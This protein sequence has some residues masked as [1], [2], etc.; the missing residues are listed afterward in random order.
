[1]EG[2]EGNRDS[3]HLRGLATVKGGKNTIS[4]PCAWISHEI[5]LPVV[6]DLKGLPHTEP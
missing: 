2:F 5:P 3:K 6:R 4:D 1:M